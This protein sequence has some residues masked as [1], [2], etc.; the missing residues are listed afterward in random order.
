MSPSD[1]SPASCTVESPC[2]VALDTD[3]EAALVVGVALC[4]LCLGSV[5]VTLWKR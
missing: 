2:V 1:T 5:M 3:L 4:A